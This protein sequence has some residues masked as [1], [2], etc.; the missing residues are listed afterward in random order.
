MLTDNNAN[1]SSPIISLFRIPMA[2]GGGA[3]ANDIVKAKK[4]EKKK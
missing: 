4:K 2:F 3:I 1:T